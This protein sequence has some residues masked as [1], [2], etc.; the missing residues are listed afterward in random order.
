MQRHADNSLALA[1][2]LESHPKV[3]SVNYPGLER[4]PSH[5]LAKKYLRTGF[6]GVLSFGLKGGYEKAK[7]FIDHVKLASHLANVGDVRTLVISSRLDYSS[8]AQR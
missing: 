2:W 6:G 5:T 7:H 4:H 8:A 3:A 1:Q